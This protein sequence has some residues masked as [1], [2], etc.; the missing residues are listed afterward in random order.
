VPSLIGGAVAVSIVGVLLG[1]MYPIAMNQAG[2]VL[3]R[4]LL[5]GSIGWIAGFG[6]AGSAALPFMTGAIS[7][8]HGIKS[9]QPLLIAMMGCMMFLWYLVPAK[10]RE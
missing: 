3:P 4:W 10:R 7:S 9:L 6:Q 2:R 1:P 8:R 5:T